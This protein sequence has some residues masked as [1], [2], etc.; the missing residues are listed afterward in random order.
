MKSKGLRFTGM[1]MLLV[2]PTF[3]SA[4][5]RARIA[6]ESYQGHD[7]A[8]NEVLENPGWGVV[9]PWGRPGGSRM[10]AE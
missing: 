3:C 2:L 1:F 4:P 9:D 7:V 6:V 8:A 10:L 5:L